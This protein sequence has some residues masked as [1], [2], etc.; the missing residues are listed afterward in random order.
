MRQYYITEG[1]STQKILNQV[2]KQQEY[3]LVH[4]HKYGQECNEFC[5]FHFA[6]NEED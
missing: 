1:V 6:E 5:E 3:T 2:N 4:Y